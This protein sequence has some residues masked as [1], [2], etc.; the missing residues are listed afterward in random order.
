MVAF[1][2]TFL[3]EVGLGSSSAGAQH[4]NCP[5]GSNTMLVAPVR[6][7]AQAMTGSGSV[8]TEDVAEGDL[9]L[10][11]AKQVNKKGLAIKLFDLFKKRKAKRDLEKN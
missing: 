7:G 9:A 1:G 3:G 4:A 5:F 11:R 10:A 6:I 2:P 8:I